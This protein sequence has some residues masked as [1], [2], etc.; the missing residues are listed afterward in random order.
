[1]RASWA[2]QLAFV[3]AHNN[4]S[5]FARSQRSWDTP[6][7]LVHKTL[8]SGT[9]RLRVEVQIQVPDSQRPGFPCLLLRGRGRAGTS[10]QSLGPE[11]RIVG[12]TG[13]T[14]ASTRVA[15]YNATSRLGKEFGT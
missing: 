9:A 1:M 4:D 15:A 7:V 10:T 11:S 14:P 6:A 12:S 2:G 5:L 3:H 13:S 8:A